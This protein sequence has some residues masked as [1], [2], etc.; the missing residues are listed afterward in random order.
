M[1]RVLSAIGVVGLLATVAWASPTGSVTGFA[2]DPTGAVVP[3]VRIT[4]ISATTNMRLTAVTDGNGSF[5]FP[6]VPPATY[7]LGAEATGFKK[8]TI[9][10]LLVQVD[11]VT[12]A[13]IALELGSVSE[14][15]E[16]TGS[17]TPLL[18]S[19]RSTMGGVVDAK[20][21]A[22]MPLNARQFMDLALLTPGAV[23]A[24]T[25]QQG[26]GFSV[27]GARTQSNVFLI[28]G[29]SNQDTQI[30]SALN[31]F[32]IGS[33][34]QEFSVQTSVALPEF[35]RGT[36]GEVNV[37]TK[38]GTNQFHGQAFEYVRNT[39]LDAA[40][41]FTNKN[42]ARKNA[43][44]RNQFGA[45]F[46]GPIF[47]DRTFFFLSYEGFRQV[48]PTVSSTRVP[49]AAEQATVTD[50]ISRRLLAHWPAPNVANPTTA[51]NYIANPRARNT[52]NTGLARIDHSFSEKD[53]ITG[54][55]I[56]F[57]GLTQVAGPTP[58]NGGNAN[59]PRSRNFVVTHTR[60]FTATLLNEFRAG[61]SRNETDITV[62]DV[63]FS[64]AS[65]F[66]DAAGRPLPGAVDAATNLVNSGLPT[67]TVAGGFAVLGSTNNLPQGRIT[68][69]Y[70][71]FDNMSLIS[72]FG[73]T[74]HSWRW[75]FHIRREDA[76]R[77]LNG[78]ARGTFNFSSFADFATGLV[79]TSIV[80]SGDTLSYWRR[81][82]IDFFWQ[83]QFKVK[84]NLTLN[85]GVR[86][87]YP[88]AIEETRNN[89]TN[90]IPGVGPVL[91]GTN[92]ILDINPS[93]LGPASF[94]YREAPFT[95]SSSG[96]GRDKNNFAPMVGFAWT[97]RVG[98][99]IFGNDATVIRGGA[100]VGYDEV[101]NNIPA[102]MS[103]NP[104][105][106]LQTSQTANVTQPGRFPWAVGFNQGVPLVSNFGRQGPGTPTRGLLGFNSIDPDIRSAYLYQYSFGIQRRLG[107]DVSVE[108][109][110][111]GSTGHKLGIFMDQN[112]PQVIVRNA[113]VRGPL[114]PNEQVYPYPKYGSVGMGKSLSNSNYNGM[115]VTGRYQGR[116]GVF[117]Q[118]SYTLGK[119]ID[120][121]SAF[122]GSNST[123]GAPSDNLNL[124]LERGPSNFD[125]RHRFVTVYVIEL[126][127]G[128]GHRLL[129]WNN[130]INRQIFGGW[131]ISGITT[132]MTGAPFTVI[133]STITD[134]SGF[135]QF[136]D[137]PDLAGTGKLPTNYQD[138]DRAFDRTYFVSGPT[139]GAIAPTGRLGTSGRNQYY[140]PALAN[141]D[142]A[143]AK[144]FPLPLSEQTRLEF[145]ADFFNLWNH[146]NFSNPQ[147]DQSNANFG[148]I[149]QTVGSAVATAVGTTA[150]PMGGPRLI[151]LALR[152]QF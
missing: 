45:T 82:P 108:I 38:S 76:R 50:P 149:T 16:V 90:F 15:V 122:F 91:V 57:Q 20:V 4:L 86:Y 71:L 8:T 3:G 25:G 84:Q 95:L 21:I 39:K 47:H 23:P 110:Y 68:N 56:E 147:R 62:Q 150:G 93:L 43:L 64:A 142:F 104:P 29:V 127:I 121:N 107:H 80:R 94:V 145:R 74:R 58:L 83:D 105:Y 152:L 11:Q 141:W 65:I 92:R 6:Q 59:V 114:A 18:E 119:S 33:A 128:P 136:L 151:Q 48:Q 30:N 88:S 144:H 101:F 17:V 42:N 73:W 148:R 125:V 34:V 102:N 19:D 55:W 124:R 77:Y 103:L 70:E 98:R 112:Q 139:G 27:A 36:G 69:T 54:R 100:R 96:V 113:A 129:G 81:Y 44:N 37:V 7:S 1:S 89:A 46:G 28:D 99:A 85:F 67:I 60:T 140:G 61:F 14:V 5:V 131:Q 109:D 137:R 40:D 51:N 66:V 118:T 116:R 117:L 126:P 31:N 78:S 32:R 72:P 79:N 130:G 138:P 134:F 41:F 10:S 106:N 97:P 146:T 22:S 26:G 35:G 115:V 49:T 52:D 63:G 135:N 133:S 120:N 53:R 123:A 111:Q 13:D 9:A 132:A 143:L 2:K 75:G 87:E 12:R 24:A